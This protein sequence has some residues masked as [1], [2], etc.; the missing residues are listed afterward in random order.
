MIQYKINHIDGLY[1]EITYAEKDVEYDVIF[2]DRKIKRDIY[3]TKMRIGTWSRL[4][5]KY[6]SDIAVI[7]RHNGRTIKQINYLDEL[8]GG[9]VLIVFESKALGDTLAWIPYCL[10]FAKIYDCEVIVSTFKNFLFESKYPEIKFVERNKI[11][12]NINARFEIGYFWDEDKEPFNP[13][14]IPLQQAICNILNLPFVEIKPEID[15]QPKMREIAQKYVCISTF[16]TSGLKEWHYWQEVVDFLVGQGY[17]V[18]EISEKQSTLNNLTP[19]TDK[20]LEN[21]MNTIYHSDFFIG[22]SS[23]LSW[24]SWTLG[25]QVFMIANFTKKDYEFQSGCIRIINEKICHGCWNNPMFRF[26]RGD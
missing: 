17:K 25:K 11:V 5:R 1:F 26:N 8:K 15:F 23:G 22:L 10:E 19:L 20:S 12:Q 6:L 18:L 4:N 3:E 24:L 21:T 2:H 9:R 7:I 14:T 13:I 16:S